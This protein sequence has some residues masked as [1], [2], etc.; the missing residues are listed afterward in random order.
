M[1]RGWARPPQAIVAAEKATSGGGRKLVVVPAS[2]AENWQD[3]IRRWAGSD[4]LILRSGDVAQPEGWQVVTIDSGKFTGPLRE[5]LCEA[6]W[7]VVIVDEAAKIRHDNTLRAA[8]IGELKV[9][10]LWLLTGTPVYHYDADLRSLLAVLEHP[11]TRPGTEFFWRVRAN[12]APELLAHWV[13][14]ISKAWLLR[15]EKS[16]VLDLPSITESVIY[17]PVPR[18]PAGSTIRTKIA[19]AKAEATLA[20]VRKI[21]ETPGE[22]VVVFSEFRAP[23]GILK[24]ALETDAGA[25]CL[26]GGVNGADRVAMV[27]RFQT[28][29][30]C[31]VFLGQIVAA[32][33]GITLT[34]GRNVVFNDIA[35]VPSYHLQGR[36]RCHRIGQTRPVL[37]KY[38]VA[39]HEYDK[40][41]WNVHCTKVREIEVIHS[42]S[43]RLR[44][45]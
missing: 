5:S 29:P 12:A 43:A 40:K 34:A 27:K 33:E 3:E 25:V 10:R 39:E 6:K 4:A 30:S 18:I 24:Q 7:D 42:A 41:R 16:A 17:V 28:D 35:S 26:H 36:D 21:L 15:R 13:R 9:D 11:F 19:K 31:R 22:K 44:A 32:G 1:N 8:L 14:K 20:L 37:V 45:S 23:L 38:V 2:L